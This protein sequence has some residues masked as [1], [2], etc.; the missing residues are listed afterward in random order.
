ML[1]S[2]RLITFSH[3]FFQFASLPLGFRGGFGLWDEFDERFPG[4]VFRKRK[5][6]WG[7]KILGQKSCKVKN[8]CKDTMNPMNQ[9]NQKLGFCCPCLASSGGGWWIFF[10][11][12]DCCDLCPSLTSTSTNNI[13][14]SGDVEGIWMNVGWLL[15]LGFV[16]NREEG[17]L[18]PFQNGL[19][20]KDGKILI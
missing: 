12:S 9:L 18:I 14:M 6:P 4:A 10:S 13:T 2:A 17:R 11:M 5:N 20:L 16:E 1:V 7:S 8:R 3:P 15:V 19:G